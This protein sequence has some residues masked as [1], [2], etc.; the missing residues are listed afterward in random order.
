MRTLLLIILSQLSI[1]CVMYD[2]VASTK[3]GNYERDRMFSFGGTT[4]QRGADGSSMVHD[5]QQSFRDATI[6]ATAI[7][8]S[9]ASASVS[10]AQE[11]TK[12][13]ADTN[14]TNATINASNN[15]TQV[16][17]AKIAAEAAPK[18]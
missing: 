12:R 8:G 13:A 5:H 9:V 11:A 2:H 18:P 1:G 3:S 15:A 7:A 4:S 16:E 17:L 10:K 6:A 14:A